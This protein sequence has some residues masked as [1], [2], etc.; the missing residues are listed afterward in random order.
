VNVTDATLLAR[1]A[2]EKA[3]TLRRQHREALADYEKLSTY[4]QPDGPQ[5]LIDRAQKAKADASALSVQLE[6]VIKAMALSDQ[7]LTDAKGAIEQAQKQFHQAREDILDLD[8][9]VQELT[10]FAQLLHR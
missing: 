6:L 9:R 5:Y 10:R 8:R 2:K 7:Q 3:D 1:Q 4:C